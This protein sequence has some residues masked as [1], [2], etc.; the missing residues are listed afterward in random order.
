MAV[1]D[2][3]IAIGSYIN[4]LKPEDQNLNS[5][6]LSHSYPTEVAGRS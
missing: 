4:P 1:S 3:K 2:N 6:L 5:H